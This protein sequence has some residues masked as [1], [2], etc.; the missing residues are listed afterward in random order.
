MMM[1]TVALMQTA[2]HFVLVKS[3]VNTRIMKRDHFVDE[4]EF[5]T[6]ICVISS[7][8]NANQ[9]QVSLFETMVNVEVYSKKLITQVSP[10]YLNTSYVVSATSFFPTLDSFY[11]SLYTTL[12][13]FAS[14]HTCKDL[15]IVHTTLDDQKRHNTLRKL[16]T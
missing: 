13:P 14:L 7:I 6:K 8:K 11:D 5:S 10:K 12:I 3:N 15:T 9:N 4:M 1:R 16:D 2:P